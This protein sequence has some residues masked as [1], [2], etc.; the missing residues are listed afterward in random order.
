MIP[1]FS[2]SAIKCYVCA[3]CNDP[4]D[5]AKASSIQTQECAGSCV[6]AK[7]DSSEYIMREKKV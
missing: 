3:G 2:A 7:A 1:F 4:W 6:K 5:K